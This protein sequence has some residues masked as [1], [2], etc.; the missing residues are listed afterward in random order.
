MN[1]QPTSP[2]A[3]TL[4]L[5]AALLVTVL[6]L[7]ACTEDDGGEGTDV[8]QDEPADGG[9][10]GD[11]GDG[12]GDGSE[13]T[14]GGSLT[15]ALSSDPGLLNPAATTSGSVHF[16]TEIMFNGLVGLDENLEPVP[17]L[18][19]DWEIEEEGALYRFNLREDVTWHDGEPFTA[20]DVKFS[21]EEVLTELHSRTAASVGSQL[22]RVEVVD[23]HTVEFHF[24]E[25]YAPLLQQ[26]D[27][28]EAAIV[29][30]HV[31]ADAESI[32]EHPASTNEP[33][34]TGPFEIASYDEGSELVLQRNDDYFKQDLPYLNEI[35]MRVIPEESSQVAALESGEVDYLSRV[36]N[37]EV[38][39]LQESDQFQVQET[40]RGA[41]A[42]NCPMTMGFNL[43]RPMFQDADVRRGI[44]WAIDRQAFVD[45]VLFGNGFVP[46]APLHRGMEWAHPG[47][48]DLPG[49]DQQRADQ[50][51]TEAGWV[52]QDGSDVRVAQGVDGV[53]DGTPF[54]MSFLAFTFHSQY[55][56]LL[57]S[58]LAEVGIDVSF[59]PLEP[60]SFIERVFTQRDFDTNI[61]SFCQGP[62]PEI[63]VRRQVD[64]R[65]IGDTPFSNAA[66]YENEQ[67]DQ[68]LDEGLRTVDTQQRVQVYRDMQQILV[69][70]LP[71]YWITEPVF[72]A[73]FTARCEGFQPFAQFAEAAHCEP[74]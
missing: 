7:G 51:L 39:R 36:P 15:V 25:P 43:D 55:G 34:G 8:S 14:R 1:A 74:Q 56:E 40:F 67:V 22:E 58:Q 61:I 72:T 52:R 11:G 27:V 24:E 62:D 66:A 68:L 32:E 10:S 57:R 47:D 6:A 30:K 35:V 53:E 63:G 19:T 49:F 71:Y 54:E 26:L 46:N 41:G 23:D 44:A 69:D 42:V 37:A 60:P 12:D 50:L 29:P 45:Q 9:D 18:A 13:P 65:Q 38:Q 4:A 64:S 31:F 3:R 48:M 59:E 21:F 17:E 73:G 28:G 70:E 5:V 33:V 2:A 16:A 20:E